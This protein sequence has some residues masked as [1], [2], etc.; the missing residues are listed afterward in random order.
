MAFQLKIQLKNVTNPP[1]WRQI[2]IPD[3]Y[4]FHQLHQLIQLIFGWEN[5]HLY[6]FSP[7]GYGSHPT[8][9]IPSKED[10]E[11]P[12]MNALK[13]KLNKVFIKEKQ[14][15]S[16]IYDFGDDW[17]HQITVEKIL[18]DE[19]KKPVC[20]SGKGACPPEDCGGP[21]GYEN[22]K[23]ILADPNHEEHLEMKEWLGLEEDEAWDSSDF[24]LDE[25]NH[26]LKDF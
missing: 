20:L 5:Y 2:I 18:P 23:V 7:K 14:I 19:I 11:K 3:N 16:Y 21:W 24:E 6:Q 26:I 9:T 25:I 8:I 1:V 4:T 22:L 13:T 17:I 15:F 12:D 10:W